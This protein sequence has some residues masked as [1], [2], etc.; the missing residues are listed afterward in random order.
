M[1]GLEYGLGPGLFQE[2]PHRQHPTYGR[3]TVMGRTV[4]SLDEWTVKDRDGRY[5]S[6]VEAELLDCPAVP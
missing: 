5:W 4:N 6:V 3:V 2:Q 1:G